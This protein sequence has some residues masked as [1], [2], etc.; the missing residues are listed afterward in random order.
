MECDENIYL[1]KSFF[2]LFIFIHSFS[3]LVIYLFNIQFKNSWNH[4]DFLLKQVV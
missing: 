2:F 3:T 1:K 4:L